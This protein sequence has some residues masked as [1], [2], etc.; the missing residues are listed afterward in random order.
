VENTRFE[1]KTSNVL[2]K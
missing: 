1:I 2:F